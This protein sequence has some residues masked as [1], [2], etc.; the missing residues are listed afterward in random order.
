MKAIFIKYIF[1][2]V[3]WISFT[4]YSWLLVYSYI[5]PVYLMEATNIAGF[6]Y[7]MYFHDQVLSDTHKQLALEVN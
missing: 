1:I 2:G 7:Q 3:V 5:T 4:L 6:R